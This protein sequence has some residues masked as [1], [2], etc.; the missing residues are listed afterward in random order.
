MAVHPAEPHLLAPAQRHAGANDA[1]ER[2]VGRLRA[3]QDGELQGGREESQPHAAADEGLGGALVRGDG[4]ERRALPHLPGPA[5]RPG[6]RAHQPRVGRGLG[7][8][9]HDLQLH[10]APAQGKGEVQG[11]QGRGEVSGLDRE[12]ARQG[13]GIEVKL[14]HALTELPSQE[15]RAEGRTPLAPRARIGLA[16]IAI[17]AD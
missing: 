13:V 4:S 12:G 17:W 1:L 2:E 3:C 10:A 16:C 7:A 11:Q 15:E 9:G 5:M 14:Q 8:A 6:Q